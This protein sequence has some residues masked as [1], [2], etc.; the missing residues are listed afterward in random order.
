M[1]K[2]SVLLNTIIKAFQARVGIC[3]KVD[4]KEEG[5]YIIPK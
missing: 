5:L 4:E 1:S 3:S 2:T